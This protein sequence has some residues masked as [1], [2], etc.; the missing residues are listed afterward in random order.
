MTHHGSVI[1]GNENPSFGG[2]DRKNSRV[3]KSSQSRGFGCVK[4]ND[5]FPA[6]RAQEDAQ[7]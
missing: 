1:M 7:V 2:C 4:V 3:W 6:N 5:R